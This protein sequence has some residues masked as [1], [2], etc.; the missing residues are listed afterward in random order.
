MNAAKKVL[1]LR[2]L[3]RHRPRLPQARPQGFGRT[4]GGTGVD[5]Y[6]RVLRG[7]AGQVDLMVPH[8][9]C[10][11]SSPAA[12]AERITRRRRGVARHARAE[13]PEIR[14][15][16]WG[17]NLGPSA[18]EYPLRSD[19]EHSMTWRRWIAT[20]IHPVHRRRVGEHLA[21]IREARLA[22]RYRS[23]A[24]EPEPMLLHCCSPCRSRSRSAPTPLKPV[25]DALHYDVTLVLG[26]TGNHVLGQ[27]QTTWLPR[28]QRSRSRSSSTRPFA[29]FGC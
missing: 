16:R 18:G 27:V 7:S 24:P 22:R 20:S 23:V 13:I 11:A 28:L 17:A 3:P 2:H 19:R 26:D 6:P 29:W 12:T 9:C 14:E 4:V 10:S 1:P 8:R 5:R 21:Q 25:H 15:I